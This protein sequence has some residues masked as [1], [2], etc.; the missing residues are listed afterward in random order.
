MPGELNVSF[1]QM[2]PLKSLVGVLVK[3]VLEGIQVGLTQY[4]GLI[5]HLAQEIGG[6]MVERLVIKF[7]NRSL[8]LC[9]E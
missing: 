3:Q 8:D 2:L 7:T 9:I 1:L 4:D 6:G 5:I